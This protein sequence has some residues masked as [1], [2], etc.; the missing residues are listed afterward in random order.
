MEEAFSCSLHVCKFIVENALIGEAAA[1]LPPTRSA[2]KFYSSKKSE[3]MADMI[4]K[5]N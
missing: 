5:I 1:K 4:L 3:H 2:L